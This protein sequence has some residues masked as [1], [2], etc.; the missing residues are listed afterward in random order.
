[1][2]DIVK[3]GGAEVI[4]YEVPKN[5]ANLTGQVDKYFGGD[6][7]ALEFKRASVASGGVEFITVPDDSG[8]KE[9]VKSISGVIVYMH[10][11]NAYWAT[12][13]IT[14]ESPVCFSR[15]GKVGFDTSTGMYR[16]CVSCPYFQFGSGKNPDGT[17][18]KGKACKNFLKVYLLR[19]GDI[20]P[21]VLNVPPASKAGITKMLSQLF[22]MEGRELWSS[23]VEFSAHATSSQ[24]GRKYVELIVRVKKTEDGKR[25]TFDKATMESLAKYAEQIE[26]AASAVQREKFD[27]PDTLGMEFEATTYGMTDVTYDTI[28]EG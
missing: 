14:G 22:F 27:E 26:V 4:S 10:P 25:V 24:G 23:P 9:M 12:K 11:A 7:S 15:D 20:L 19:E 1:M 5:I 17:K 18:S 3:K 13:E 8:E 21:L 16:A 2:A 6:S 28:Q